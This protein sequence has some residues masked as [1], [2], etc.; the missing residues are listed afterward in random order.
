MRKLKRRVAKVNMK[1]RGL[2]QICKGK[3]SYFAQ[4]WREWVKR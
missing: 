3:P 1:K 4:N 2:V